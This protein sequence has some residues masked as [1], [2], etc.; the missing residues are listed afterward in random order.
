M[1]RQESFEDGMR[2]I[3]YAVSRS[4]L[5]H[6]QIV[7]LLRQIDELTYEREFIWEQASADATEIPF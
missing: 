6:E 4:K 5:I 3:E 2:R 1:T 7:E